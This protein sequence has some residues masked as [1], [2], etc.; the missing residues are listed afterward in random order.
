MRKLSSYV[1]KKPKPK[2]T[3]PR[4]TEFNK[5]VSLDLK[6]FEGEGKYADILYEFDLLSRLTVAT[7][8]DRKDAAIVDEALLRY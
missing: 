3:I 8:I 7:F 4:V 2:I 5:A 6:V 1:N